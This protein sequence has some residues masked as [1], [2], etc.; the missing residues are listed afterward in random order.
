MREKIVCHYSEQKPMGRPRKRQLNETLNG[1]EGGIFPHVQ[2]SQHFPSLFRH[3][4]AAYN[5]LETQ[6]NFIAS[7]PLGKPPSQ[8]LPEEGKSLESERIAWHFGDNEIMNGPPINFGTEDVVASLPVGLAPQE[9]SVSN[10]PLV[11]TE[12]STKQSV[13]NGNCSCLASMYLSLAALQQ[14]PTEIVPALNTVRGAAATASHS[15]VSLIAAL[16][17]SNILEVI[18][19][20]IVAP[21]ALHF[22]IKIESPLC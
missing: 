20:D 8:V 2:D 17:I 3:E 1:A 13:D 7:A 15:I 21:L 5:D 16:H 18:F 9:P 10:P 22:Q 11:E 12:S 14:F 6:L 19:W 4:F